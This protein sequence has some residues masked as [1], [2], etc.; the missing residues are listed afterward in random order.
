M[1]LYRLRRGDSHN[2]M[3]FTSKRKA[4]R[5]RIKDSSDEIYMCWLH[6][7]VTKQSIVEFLNRYCDSQ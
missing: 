5:E 4:Q 3:W 1:R 2:Q 7:P 6:G